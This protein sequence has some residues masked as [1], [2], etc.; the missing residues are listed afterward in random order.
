MKVSK[1]IFSQIKT[2]A[3]CYLMCRHYCSISS[4]QRTNYSTPRGKALILY[5]ILNNE[6]KM[7]DELARL[8]YLCTNCGRCYVACETKASNPPE[9]FEEIRAL[10]VSEGLVPKDIA[11]LA[12]NLSEKGNI[13]GSP[14][15]KVAK[16]LPKEAFLDGES[17]LLYYV[18]GEVRSAQPEIAQAAVELLKTI[19]VDVKV[20]ENEPGDG[21][22]LYILGFR[23]KARDSAEKLIKEL[24][25]AHVKTL[26]VSDPLSYAAFKI[27]YPK[28]GL[29]LGDLKVVHLTEFLVKKPISFNKLEAATA[30]HDPC[31]LGRRTNNLYDEPREL[32]RRIPGLDLKEPE[33]N[34]EH[35][36][37]CGG[38]LRPIDSYWADK[39]AERIAEEFKRLEIDFATTSC[40]RCKD[41]F[42][43]VGIKTYDIA[44][45]LK[46]AASKR[47]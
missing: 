40:P 28:L 47:G 10:E 12:E 17:D 13:Y 39:V 6:F 44:E 33:F 5:G 25:K 14:E 41:S 21:G 46:M 20:L 35:S 36:L 37:C 32:L 4:V 15:D 26:I 19:G 27:Y 3:F 31:F 23:E 30:Y 29:S 45:V 42:N 8:F 1:E 11:K 2:C 9:I 22:M 43:R 34:R 24:K 38:L 18:G 7:N 16:V